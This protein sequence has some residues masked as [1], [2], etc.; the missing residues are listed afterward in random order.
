M[1]DEPALNGRRLVRAEVIEHHVDVEVPRHRRI[2][3]IEELLELDRT[4]S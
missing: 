1:P 2:D 3:R 4:V